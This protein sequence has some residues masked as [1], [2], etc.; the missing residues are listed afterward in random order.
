MNFPTEQIDHVDTAKV[1]ENGDLFV[2]ALINDAIESRPAI[3]NPPELAE[4]VEYSAAYCETVIKQ[5]E[6][7]GA[8]E[9]DLNKIACILT[10][11]NNRNE[12]NESVLDNANWW[13]QTEY[14]I[15]DYL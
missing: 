10:D 13:I 2:I 8:E 15:G 7:E 4:P 12:I 5:D 3:Y 14:S 11:P 1:L 6:I 9:L